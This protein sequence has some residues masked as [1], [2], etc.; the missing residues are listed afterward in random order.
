MST[1]VGLHLNR[2]TLFC[3]TAVVSGGIVA[4]S[5]VCGESLRASQSHRTTLNRHLFSTGAQAIAV[6]RE[7]AAMK[8]LIKKRP[9]AAA[10]NGVGS[11]QKPI[12]PNTA[13]MIGNS[14]RS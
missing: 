13:P 1:T 2:S 4:S 14:E 10:L 7:N 11:T 3:P 12:T 9:K 5:F 8:E 6:R